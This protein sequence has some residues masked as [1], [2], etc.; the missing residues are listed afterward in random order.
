MFFMHVWDT[1][2]CG[3]TTTLI[4]FVLLSSSLSLSGAVLSSKHVEGKFGGTD[5]RKAVIQIFACVG[6]NLLRSR[7]VGAV[8]GVVTATP[9][10]QR[11]LYR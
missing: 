5:K 8:T 11:K 9:Y 10:P 3:T 2:V 4:N 6:C 7:D 1:A